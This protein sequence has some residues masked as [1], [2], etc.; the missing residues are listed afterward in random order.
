MVSEF[1]IFLLSL[2][3]FNLSNLIIVKILFPAPQFT[4]GNCKSSMGKVHL[5]SNESNP[6][7]IKSFDFVYFLFLNKS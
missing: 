2:R 7:D 6:K 1:L 5:N 3:E 4:E